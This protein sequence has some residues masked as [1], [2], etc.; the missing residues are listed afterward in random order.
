[1]ER[2]ANA[3]SEGILVV[4]REQETARK[5]WVTAAVSRSE[6]E[7]PLARLTDKHTLQ[8]THLIA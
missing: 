5:T 2:T 8:L 1:M 4:R 7:T 3:E 6:D